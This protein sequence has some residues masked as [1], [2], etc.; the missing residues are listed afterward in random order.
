[1][2]IVIYIPSWKFDIFKKEL[3]NNNFTF[4]TSY[5]DITDVM[6]LIIMIKRDEYQKLANTVRSAY[7]KC[8][9]YGHTK[10]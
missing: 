7:S 10:H 2:K 4:E 8:E 1:M 5:N 6:M 9:H 3:E